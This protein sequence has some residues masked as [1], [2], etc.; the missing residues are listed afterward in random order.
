MEVE[1]LIKQIVVSFFIKYRWQK[2]TIFPTD[3]RFILVQDIDSG[4]N[5]TL[6]VINGMGRLL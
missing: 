2:F 3:D 5:I 4:Y 6:L 1:V